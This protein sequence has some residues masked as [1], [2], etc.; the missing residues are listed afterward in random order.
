MESGLVEM[1]GAGPMAGGNKWAVP[2]GNQSSRRQQ[3]M[4]ASRSY[5]DGE[6][7]DINKHQN[8]QRLRG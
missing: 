7:I 1:M 6:P 3:M 4:A 8:R 5:N 2:T